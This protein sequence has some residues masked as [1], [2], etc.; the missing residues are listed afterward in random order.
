MILY[1]LAMTNDMYHQKLLCC[2]NKGFCD[3]AIDIV[4]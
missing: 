1:N 2:V 4:F 3:S